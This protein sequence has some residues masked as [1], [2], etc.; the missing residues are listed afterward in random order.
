MFEVLFYKDRQ[1][2]E[3]IR[4]YIRELNNKAKTSKH[5]RVKLKKILEY[6]A[7][8]EEFGTRI[9]EPIVKHIDAGIW[10]IRPISDRILFFYWKDDKFILLHHFAKKTRKTPQREIDKAKHNLN[11][12][13]ERNEW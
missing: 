7:I 6:I 5:H 13:L 11:D 1:G 10:E 2:N 9:G 3:P 4:D 12:F 8:L